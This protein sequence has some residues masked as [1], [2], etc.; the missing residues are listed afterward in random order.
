MSEDVELSRASFCKL[1]WSGHTGHHCGVMHCGTAGPQTPPCWSCFK[2]KP[3]G[4]DVIRI[5]EDLHI[6]VIRANM[7]A[8][9]CLIISVFHEL[10][11]M[12]FWSQ[13]DFDTFIWRWNKEK[14]CEVL[15]RLLF[16]CLFKAQ[17]ELYLLIPG[18]WTQKHR[19]LYGPD[20]TVTSLWHH[21][22]ITPG[23]TAEGETEVL[24]NF[25]MKVFDVLILNI[26]VMN[27]EHAERKSTFNL[28]T[29]T[30]AHTHTGLSP[31]SH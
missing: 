26:K 11:V 27:V 8:L 5:T 23:F 16:W 21:S 12:I 17:T 20:V 7:A 2:D 22:D 24:R 18:D 1:T 31:A 3:S 28:H 4:V 19:A 30:H 9:L 13:R 15:I 14:W 6:S 10:N 25:C 29:H